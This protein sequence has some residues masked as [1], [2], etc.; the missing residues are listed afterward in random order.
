M[1]FHINMKDL[2]VTIKKI[3]F[4]NFT[5]MKFEIAAILAAC[6][7]ARHNSGYG[8]S[9]GGQLDS[10]FGGRSSYNPGQG[11]GR[12]SSRGLGDLSSSRG[13]GDLSSIGDLKSSKSSRFGGQSYGSGPSSYGSSKG[14]G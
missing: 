1:L 10:G 4:V 13:L 5:N 6:A 14:Y 7:F 11:Y 3:N 12:S 9:F 8:G 2:I